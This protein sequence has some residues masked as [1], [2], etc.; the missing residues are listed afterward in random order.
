MSRNYINSSISPIISSWQLTPR[1][2]SFV[3]CEGMNVIRTF[4]YL[5]MYVLIENS[6]LRRHIFDCPPT[7]LEKYLF[8]CIEMN[9]S[10][11]ADDWDEKFIR[12][13]SADAKVPSDYAFLGK[14]P[15]NC[16][17]FGCVKGNE[18]Q[19]SE[20]RWVESSNG[21]DARLCFYFT[22]TLWISIKVLLPSERNE[23]MEQI[24]LYN[25]CTGKQTIEIKFID[26][27]RTL[28]CHHKS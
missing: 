22:T 13:T 14:R 19:W 4:F 1:E 21:K 16:F 12:T 27:K 11:N 23:A 24:S 18:R 3:S 25:R 17:I 15:H 28:K 20:R 5:T 9:S 10:G 2:C 8:A 7:R 26:R 6:V